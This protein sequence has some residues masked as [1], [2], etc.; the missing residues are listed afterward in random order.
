[1]VDCD[2]GYGRSQVVEGAGC[3][4]WRESLVKLVGQKDDGC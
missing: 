1:M 3:C 4:H 2:D